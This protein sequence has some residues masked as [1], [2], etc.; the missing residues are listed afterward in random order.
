VAPLSAVPYCTARPQRTG[1]PHQAPLGVKEN[2]PKCTP[3]SSVLSSRTNCGVYVKDDIVAES[4]EPVAHAAALAVPRTR[5]GICGHAGFRIRRILPGGCV[6]D[7]AV[8]L[9]PDF[10]DAVRDRHYFPLHQCVAGPD[11]AIRTPCSRV[12]VPFA[13]SAPVPDYQCGSPLRE[14]SVFVF[15]ASTLLA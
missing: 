10:V 8:L 1:S 13:I 3:P 11:P 4:L 2:R 5:D 14:H 15:H 12:P 6:L 7:P 9:V